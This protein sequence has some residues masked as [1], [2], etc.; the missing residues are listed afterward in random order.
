MAGK[1]YKKNLSEIKDQIYDIDQALQL[2]LDWNSASFDESMDV[3]VRLGIDPKKPEEQVRGAVILPQGLGR[4]VKVLVFAKGEKE[5]EARKAGADF[6]GAEDMVKKIKSGWLAFDRVLALPDMMPIVASVAKIL[7]PKALMPSP[8]TG[9]VTVR[10]G[11]AVQDEKRGKAIFRS[12]KNG[13]LQSSFGK[14][15]MGFEKLKQNYLALMGELIKLKPKSSKG[16]Y[17]KSISLS[18]TMSPGLRVKSSQ[19]EQEAI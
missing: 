2:I 18:S 16:L 6:V 13:I 19:T 9:S 4:T 15:S 5:E 10:I 12:D 3:A 11:P 8:K 17:L 14:K 7:G 1:R